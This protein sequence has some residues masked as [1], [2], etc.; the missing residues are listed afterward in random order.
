MRKTTLALSVSVLILGL[1][2]IPASPAEASFSAFVSTD[3]LN[4]RAAPNTS[5]EIID[6]LYGGDPVYV[7]AEVFGE[8]V[9]GTS[10]W[11]Q[12]DSGGYVTSAYI[13]ESAGGGDVFGGYGRWIDVD[14]SAQTATAYEGDT[15]VYTALVTTGKPGFETPTGTFTIFSRVY[16]ETMVGDDYY[17]DNVLFTQYF[18]DGGYALHTN[19]WQPSYVFGNTPTSHGCVGMPYGDAAFLWEF[20][21]YGTPVVIHY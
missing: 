17:Q 6:V 10:T 1:V 8:T 15:P 13:G 12:L 20:A 9:A 16:N 7:V 4:V 2:L 19:Y 18:A 14:L 11:Y 5:A 3:A 21:D